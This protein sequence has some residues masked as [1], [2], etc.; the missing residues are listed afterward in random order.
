MTHE[1]G[2]ICSLHTETKLMATSSNDVRG[3]MS[4]RCLACIDMSM[5][6]ISVEMVNH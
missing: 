6:G 1:V 4:R 3:L 5:R 2:T